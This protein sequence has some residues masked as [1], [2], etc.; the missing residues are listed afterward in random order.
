[1]KKI[2]AA[3]FN[4]VD[5]HSHVWITLESNSRSIGKKVLHWLSDF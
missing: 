4:F 2:K 5:G 1:M 3:I